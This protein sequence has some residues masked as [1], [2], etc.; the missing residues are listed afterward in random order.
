MPRNNK[1]RK[2]ITFKSHSM[3]AQPAV[4]KNNQKKAENNPEANRAKTDKNQV[5]SAAKSAGSPGFTAQKPAPAAAPVPAVSTT[6][7]GK[8]TTFHFDAPAAKEVFLAGEFTQWDKQPIHLIKGGGG[9][10]HTKVAL[11]PGRHLYRFLVDGQWQNDPVHH[12]RVPNTFGSFNNVIE[13]H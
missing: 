8:E 6:A 1:L 7:P 3:N 11:P 12:E 10:W 2:Q 9:V 13:V 5:S 4:A